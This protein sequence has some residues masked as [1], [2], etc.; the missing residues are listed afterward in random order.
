MEVRNQPIPELE[1]VILIYKNISDARNT[2]QKIFRKQ[3]IFT[4]IC[5]HSQRRDTKTQ[6]LL[7]PKT[8]LQLAMDEREPV[9][10]LN[11]RKSSHKMISNKNG[12]DEQEHSLVD[13]IIRRIA[14]KRV[15]C[16]SFVTVNK[17][18]LH[19]RPVLRNAE[20][21]VLPRLNGLPFGELSGQNVASKGLFS[22]SANPDRSILNSSSQR[23]YDRIERTLA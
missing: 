14:F 15:T 7:L 21:T 2:M 20:S 5:N 10:P 18:I 9:S 23:I 3:D 1:R 4:N 19:P 17:D 8:S 6:T 16:S 13:P 22:P 12:Q 11:F